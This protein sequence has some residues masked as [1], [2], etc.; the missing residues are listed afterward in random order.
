MIQNASPIWFEDEGG[1]DVGKKNES[2]PF[3]NG[4]DLVIAEINC[5][6]RDAYGENDREKMWIDSSKYLACIRHAG[7]IGADSHDIRAEQCRRSDK[8]E[9]ARAD[10]T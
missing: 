4:S 10:L 9:P 8:L 2:E 7:E 1:K 5:S 3:Q 6:D